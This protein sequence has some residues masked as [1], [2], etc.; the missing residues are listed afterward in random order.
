MWYCLRPE[1][2]S[3]IRRSSGDHII[4]KLLEMSNGF[5]K[6]RSLTF[7]RIVLYDNFAPAALPY[8][9]ESIFNTAQFF[10][11]KKVFRICD[12]LRV[13]ELVLFAVRASEGND[14][15]P[16]HSLHHHHDPQLADRDG[17]R[18]PAFQQSYLWPVLN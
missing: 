14:G 9:D 10:S 17:K 11:T 1:E 3:D 8:C 13:K 2:P 18:D 15:S 6:F 5:R 16:K 4:P 7:L 12:I